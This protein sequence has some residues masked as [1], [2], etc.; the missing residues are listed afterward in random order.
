MRTIDRPAI[1]KQELRGMSDSELAKLGVRMLNRKDLVLQCK[2][3]AET[4]APQLDSSGKL[5]FDYWHCPARC[6]EVAAA[7]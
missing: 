3:C 6:N 1:D 2:T 5:P 7:R 4:W